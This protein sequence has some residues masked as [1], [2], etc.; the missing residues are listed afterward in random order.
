MSGR[1]R[2]VPLVPAWAGLSRPRPVRARLGR[3]DDDCI[4]HRGQ[5]R[6]RLRDRP[7][8][9][10]PRHDRA[11]RRAGRDPRP[12]RPSG[13][14]ARAARRP[15]SC[16]STSPTRSRVRRPR[17]GSTVSTACW[18]SWSTTPG[19]ARGDGTGKPSETTLATLRD[20]F[21]TNVFGVVAVTNAMLPLLRRAP[22]GRIVNVSSEVGSITLDDRPG[23]PAVAAWP[24]CPT[25]VQGR[26]EHG[27]RHVREGALRHPGQGQRGQPGLLRHRPERHIPASAPR[28]GRR[29][30]RAP[31]HAACRRADRRALGTPVGH[32]RRRVLRRAALVGRG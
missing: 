28:A 29:D 25:R 20:V 10:R 13:R 26:A 27:D 3:H 7:A 32:R 24:R 18:T 31:G 4:D 2:V 1:R 30:Q 23:R 8:A 17:S 16:R 6:H 12:A 22:A 21:E 9:R 14:C 11:A 5:Q 19:I 15:G